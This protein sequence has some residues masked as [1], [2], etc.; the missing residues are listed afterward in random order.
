MQLAQFISENLEPILDEWVIFARSCGVAG[1]EM[2]VVSLRDHAAEMLQVIVLDLQTPQTDAEQN[3]KGKGLAEAPVSKQETAAEIHGAGRAESGFTLGEMVSEYRALRASVL[4]LWGQANPAL[5]PADFEDLMRFNEAIDQSLAESVTRYTQDID[6]AREMFVAVLGHDL[7]TPLSAVLMATTFMRDSGELPEPHQLLSGR[8]VSS[9]TRM[10]RMVDDL[11]DFTRSRL[12]SGIPV[13][14]VPADLQVVVQDAVNEI[15]AAFPVA[16]IDLDVR[17]ELD[18]AFDAPR[19]TQALINLLGNAVQYGTPGGS[20]RVAASGSADYVSL[21]VQNHGPSIPPA[22][23]SG[24]FSP[25]KRLR[26]GDSARYAH[27]L[28]LGLYIAER[29]ITAHDGTIAVSSS[30]EAGTLFRIRLPRAVARPS[31]SARRQERAAAWPDDRRIETRRGI[32]S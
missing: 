27:N 30:D 23:L 26:G 21:E 10:A 19:I 32:R 3:A 6:G 1:R 31:D 2:D 7:R 15:R 4:R 17:G 12:G 29:I 5:T 18:G 16:R 14:R 24:L 20:I 8:V 13:D 9:A 28:G 25:F 11:L 22:S